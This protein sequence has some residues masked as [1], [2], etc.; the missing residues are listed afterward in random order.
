MRWLSAEG[1]TRSCLAAARKLPSS[2]MAQ[3]AARSLMFSF[4]INENISVNNLVLRRLFHHNV[5]HRLSSFSFAEDPHKAW[6]LDD[7]WEINNLVGRDGAVRR[8]IGGASAHADE[9]KRILVFGD[10]NSWGWKAKLEAFPVERFGDDERWAGVMATGLGEDYTVIVDGLNGRTTDLD[11]GEDLGA[12]AAEDFNGAKDLPEVLAKNLPLDL[13]VVMLGTNDA[14]AQFDRNADQVAQGAMHLVDIVRNIN[15]GVLTTYGTPKVLLVTPP[16]MGDISKPRFRPTWRAVLKSRNNLLMHLIVRPSLPMCRS[17]MREVSLAPVALM[18]FISQPRNTPSLARP[19][20]S[21][22]RQVCWLTD[23]DY[24][25]RNRAA[26]GCPVSNLR[27]VNSTL[28]RTEQF[29]HHDP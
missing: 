17:L 11:F 12:L 20:Q 7:V 16:P 8:A 13:V 2:I 23:W 26:I 18:A 1:V 22:S 3:K 25:E 27:V 29:Q 14:Q 19:L 21:K 5:G 15:G 28:R 24:F 10:S 6:S 9:A 4:T